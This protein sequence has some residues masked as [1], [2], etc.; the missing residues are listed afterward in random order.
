MAMTGRQLLISTAAAL[1]LSACGSLPH[2]PPRTMVLDT[3]NGVLCYNSA[4]QCYHLDLIVANNYR[5]ELLRVYG[6]NPWDWKQLD[7]P[8]EL[9]ELLLS[10]VS[11]QPAA[12][13]IDP[14]IYIL[15]RNKHS[16]TAWR[17]L[18]QEHRIRFANEPGD[19]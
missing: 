9:T 13:Q 1:A 11:G 14:F 15:P 6:R 8:I 10:P 5:D 7:S 19:D 17:V 16:M 2:V 4:A 18:Q 3:E 12:R